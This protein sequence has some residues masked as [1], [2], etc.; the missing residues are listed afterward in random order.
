MASRSVS[1]CCSA[2][3][4][5]ASENSGA[6]RAIP[7]A[8]DNEIGTIAAANSAMLRRGRLFAANKSATSAATIKLAAVMI[9]IA[10]N[11]GQADGDSARNAYAVVQLVLA[12]ALSP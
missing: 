4:I 6:I 7:S 8:S 11:V 5:L 2:R 9:N 3:E 1:C 12:L 10:S